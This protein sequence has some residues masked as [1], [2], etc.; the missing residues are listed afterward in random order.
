ML[1][2]EWRDGQSNLGFRAV[3]I[4]PGVKAGAAIA[5][6][7]LMKGETSKMIESKLE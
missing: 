2:T 7:T 1:S 5:R 6:I 4:V 3:E